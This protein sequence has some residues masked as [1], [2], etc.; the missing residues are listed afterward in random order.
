LRTELTSEISRATNAESSLRSD[1]TSE[2]SRATNA[3]SS[4]RSD[5]TSEISRATSAEST[6]IS[7]M[8]RTGTIYVNDNIKDIQ[9]GINEAV[10]GN[11]IMVSMGSYGGNTVLLSGK[12]NIAI[13]CPNRGQQ[14]ICELSGGR[15]LTI[16]SSC[17]GSITISN[18]QIEGLFTI[19]GKGNNYFTDLQCKGGITIS[20]GSTGYYFF[21]SCEISG[22]IIVPSTFQGLITFNQCNFSGATF[23][24][25]NPSPL[26]VQITLCLNL[27][28]TRPTSATYGSANADTN[29]SITTDTTYLRVNNSL[30]T[31]GQFSI[32]EVIIIQHIGEIVCQVH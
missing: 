15:G 13:I 12:S 16:D 1:L 18:L 20:P 30:G 7:N 32:V 11:V 10:V 4:L 26:Q 8:I 29:L 22:A 19:A 9:S 5:L 23:S 28:V 3:E 2:I 17:T 6:I 14:T 24:F 21:K 27:P 31:N 25:N